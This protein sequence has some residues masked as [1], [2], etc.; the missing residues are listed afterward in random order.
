MQSVGLVVFLPAELAELRRLIF[1]V[2]VEDFVKILISILNQKTY[3]LKHQTNQKNY[4]KL[5]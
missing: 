3:T 5:R 1:V 4:A 2:F